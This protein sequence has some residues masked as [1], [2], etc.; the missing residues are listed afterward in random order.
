MQKSNISIM[1]PYF[2]RYVE[3]VTDKNLHEVLH[4]SLTHLQTEETKN[5]LLRIENKKYAENKWTGKQIIQHITDAERVFAYRALRFA[6][7]DKTV[8]QG[9]DENLF[10]E[11]AHIAHRSFD[12]LYNELIS[13]RQ[14]TIFL[15]KSFTNDMLLQTGKTNEFEVAVLAL[16]F[17]IVGHQN[18]HLQVVQ[19]RYSHL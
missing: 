12:D 6:R 19:E 16:G 4:D 3:L 17:A 13:V 11:H 9:Y 2:N 5:L 15:F 1:P 18:H 10:A 7:H 14:S 8:L